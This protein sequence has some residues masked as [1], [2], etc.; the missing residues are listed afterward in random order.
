[1]AVA[2]ALKITETPVT[3]TARKKFTNNILTS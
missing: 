1:A 3:A 2:A